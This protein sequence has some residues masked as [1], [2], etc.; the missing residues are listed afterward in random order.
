MTNAQTRTQDEILGD[1]NA[2]SPPGWENKDIKGEREMGLGED[3]L[4]QMLLEA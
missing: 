4:K 3:F 2:A 1:P